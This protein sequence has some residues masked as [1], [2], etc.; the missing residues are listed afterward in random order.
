MINI[1]L[2]FD[3][4]LVDEYI[5]VNKTI[6]NLNNIEGDLNKVSAEYRLFRESLLANFSKDVKCAIELAEEAYKSASFNNNTFLIEK[7]SIHLGYMYTNCMNFE[8]AIDYYL[9]ALK[10]NDHP[11]VI[12]NIGVIFH[13]LG[14]IEEA[15]KYFTTAS[16]KIDINHSERLKSIIYNNIA[17][18]ECEFGNYDKAKNLLTIAHDIM[19]SSD[20]PIGTSSLYN[21]YGLIETKKNNYE[22]AIEYFKLG[23]ANYNI[24][25]FTLH[26]SDLLRNHA[27]V[28]FELKDYDGVIE[29]LTLIE[30]LR[31][32]H[33]LGDKN[34][35]DL[36]LLARVHEQKNNYQK[37]NKAYSE[38]IE[39]I[40]N[41]E[42]RSIHTRVENLKSKVKLL[43]ITKKVTA[44]ERI[45]QTDSLTGIKNRY[46]LTEYL[47]RMLASNQIKTETS[48]VLVDVDY[49]KEFNDCYGHSLGDDC[50]K[51]IV[52]QLAVVLDNKDNQLFRYGGDEF[53]AVLPNISKKEAVKLVD[54]TK[55]KISSLRIPN[56]NSKTCKFITCSFGL[57]T[58]KDINNM[59]FKD[60]LGVVDKALYEAKSRG[61]NQISY[62]ELS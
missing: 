43:E 34:C 41:N 11:R 22:K 4:I 19:L 59:N 1:D 40:K 24:E 52:N 57:T 33:S 55:K 58:I 30:S 26:Y 15:Y 42:M 10:H 29:K 56:K 5:D 20:N 27:N 9:V 44:L 53:F 35:N 16:Q 51:K 2:K 49:F 46:S 3:E 8:K 18:C 23:E 38:Y 28:L 13:I 17:E 39:V 37:S 47:K 60:V 48:I 21:S 6:L 45:S 12:N 32:E 61:R 31:L 50:L 14:D 36:F 62:I 7:I 25:K 54:I